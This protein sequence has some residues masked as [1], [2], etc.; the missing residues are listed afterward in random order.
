MSTRAIVLTT[1]LFTFVLADV[2]AA[3]I[4]ITDPNILY[5]LDRANAA[6]SARGHLAATKGS[7]ADVRQFGELMAGEHHVLRASG[8][9]LAHKLG[10]TQQA[11]SDDKSE[12][13]ARTEMAKLNSMPRGKSWD[14]SYI[15]Y[16]VNYHQGILHSAG[17]LLDAAQNEQ[18]KDLLKASGAVVQK[19]L[20][21]AKTIQQTLGN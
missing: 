10:V 2:G 5:I 8:E 3:K 14:R 6:D 13:Q 19:H 17:G 4:G 18:L 12:S 15:A 16:E 1:V 7:S 11:P 21:L 20:G 9:Q